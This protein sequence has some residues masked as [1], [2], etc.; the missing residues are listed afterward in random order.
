MPLPELGKGMYQGFEGGFYPGGENKPPAAHL[1]AGLKVAKSVVP[2]DADGKPSPDGKIVLL[3]CG[4]SNTAMEFQVF[5][6]QAAADKSLNL[7][8][9]IADGAQGGRTA[10]VTATSPDSVDQAG[11]RSPDARISRGRET[12]AT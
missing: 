1:K 4:M 6:K 11:Q 2:L 3:S 9:V 10:K 7:H 8:L 12:P 5:Q